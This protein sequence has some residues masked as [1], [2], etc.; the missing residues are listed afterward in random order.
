M[1]DNGDPKFEFKIEIFVES[2]ESGFHAYCPALKGLH[3]CGDTEEEA[4]NNAAD[5]AI[6][7]LRSLIKHGDPI[8]VGIVATEEVKRRAPSSRRECPHHHTKQLMVAATL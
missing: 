3:T 5:A 6:A 2:D 7:Y 8:P 4:L 1:G